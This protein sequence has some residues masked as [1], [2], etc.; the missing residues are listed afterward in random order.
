MNILEKLYMIQDKKY[1]AFQA[2]LTPNIPPEKFIGVRIPDCRRLAK[3]LSKENNVSSFLDRLPH[4]YYDENTI[5]IYNEELRRQTSY[6]VS[7][8]LL[9][10]IRSRNIDCSK[11]ETYVNILE[12][13]SITISKVTI[14]AD[15][16]KGAE[17]IVKN[18]L[19]EETEVVNGGQ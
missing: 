10:Q 11:I 2:K 18:C 9:E 19:G 16:F 8:V 17:K 1:A 12:D 14:I 6:N 3:E 13:G 15:D 7:E 5:E 4:T